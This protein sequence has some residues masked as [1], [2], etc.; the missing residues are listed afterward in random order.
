[1]VAG[2]GGGGA[3]DV[4]GV[5]AIELDRVTLAGDGTEGGD[6]VAYVAFRCDELGEVPGGDV[7]VGPDAVAGASGGGGVERSVDAEPARCAVDR[8]KLAMECY[9]RPSPLSR[10]RCRV[11]L[12]TWALVLR[13]RWR[14]VMS[15]ARQL[16]LLGLLPVLQ[17]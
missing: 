17:A 15:S 1:M 2:V 3:P 9:R 12:L 13:V 11:K 6:A 4:D 14:V 5:A 10:A 8:G 7:D 16:T